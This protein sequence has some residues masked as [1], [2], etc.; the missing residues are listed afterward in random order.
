MI[1]PLW[2]R[3]NNTDTLHHFRYDT[4]ILFHNKKQIDM[5]LFI[6]PK[7]FRPNYV[8]PPGVRPSVRPLAIW[9]P[10]HNLSPIWPIVFKLYKMMVHI[11]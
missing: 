9:F 7:E 6:C 5:F 3:W 10:E 2:L 1:L 11:G 4:L 8:I